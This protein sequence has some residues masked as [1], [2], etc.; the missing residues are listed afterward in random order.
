MTTN[1]KNH[2]KN[3]T[4]KKVANTHSQ[5]KPIMIGLVYANW[6][7][8]C[9]HL[10]PEWEKM[11]ESLL[12]HPHFKDGKIIEIEDGDVEKEEKMKAIHP[13]LTVGG[14]PTIFKKDS[15]GIGYYSGNRHSNELLKWALEKKPLTGGYRYRSKSITTKS[16]KSIRKSA[17]KN[18]MKK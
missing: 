13:N 8:H 14:Y 10:K 3:Y 15:K 6:C 4:Q 9:Q 11:K 2:K 7:G 18:V 12:K 5:H 17:T 16:T 1:K